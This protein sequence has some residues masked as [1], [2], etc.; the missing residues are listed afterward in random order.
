MSKG[1]GFLCAVSLMLAGCGFVGGGTNN[2]GGG[3]T[4]DTGKAQGV[5]SGTTSSGYY[6]ETILL[7]NDK[8]YEIYGTLIG[9][10]YS[11]AG[12]VTGQGASGNGTYTAN[13]NEFQYTG[14]ALTDGLSATVV[15][16]SSLGGTLIPFGKLSG[17]SFT[18]TAPAA[19][20]FDYNVPASLADISGSWTGTLLDGTSTTV[21]MN[22]DGTV[23]GSASGCPFSGTIVADPSDKNFFDVSVKFGNAP[24]SLLNQTASGVAVDFLLPDG[25][26]R[27]L[28]L[29]V[30]QG[31]SAGTAFLAQRSASGGGSALGALNGQYAF[32]LSGF[33]PTGN[34]ISM[35][36]SIKA[37]GL[38]HITAGE[39]DV[40]DNGM[41][42]SNISLAGTYAFDS[43]IPPAGTFTFNS[44]A[45]GTLGTIALTYTVGTVSHPLAFG[46]SLQGD[47]SFG[48]IMS[49][50]TNNFVA[51]GSMEQQSAAAFTPSG[52]AGDYIVALHG[53]S[54]GNAT[55]ALGRF[56]L[57]SGGA[58]S[59]VSF[60][61]S[62]AG[63][64]SAGPTSGASASVVF[65][66]AGPDGNGRGTFTV[67]LN[68]TLGH[69]TQE[70]AYYAI[71]GKRM[72]AVEADGSG[73]MTADFSGQS[74][75]FTAATV[76]TGGSVFGMAGVDPAA[77][78][79]EIAAVGQLQIT[80]VGT[81]TG[82]LRWDSNDAGII[83]G[84][85][86]FASQAVPVFEA[87]SGRGT[88]TI[89]GGAAGGLADSVVFYL[90]AP[91]T[92]FIMDTT[93]GI[94]NRAMAGTLKAQAGGPY[95]VLND[96]GGLGIV[97]TGGSTMNDAISLVGLFGLTTSPS[98]YAL[99][100][101]QRYP[102]NGG[103]QTQ[104]DQSAANVAVQG[105]D[106][107]TGRGTLTLPSGGK[108]ATEAF[109]VVGPNQFVFI[110][111]SSVSSG[112]NGPSS[113]FYVDGH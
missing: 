47:G 111:V 105:V 93:G 13:V 14:Q 22:S 90:S 85:A 96:L 33:D 55:A 2:N 84:P 88:V 35:A 4:G 31:D 28:W 45:Q 6:F 95:T 21:T 11:V 40:N 99:A 7:P 25:V 65:G 57:G 89:A 74:T 98:T 32:S 20:S 59:N 107:V 78:S 52:L 16:D 92:G 23:S 94:N 91:G 38:G 77:A 71:T 79:N 108:T 27:Q 5:Y 106:E 50:D 66:S 24:C 26:T 62:M 10:L 19:S 17:V 29:V 44:N 110:D 100:Y 103:I 83:V 104:L 76:V 102:K 15:P 34:P 101:D 70:F 112:L 46:F 41:I 58:S 56:T 43:N 72:I 97:R 82:A 51:S 8:Y 68:D 69:T 12:M 80:G 86:F 73:T 64:G 54:A 37:D 39:V 61:R 9:N 53:R 63:V 30:T 81:N 113:L 75:P 1:F 42:S 3:G 48:Q 87:G 36:G 109:Y 60:D 18:G 49:L 67:T